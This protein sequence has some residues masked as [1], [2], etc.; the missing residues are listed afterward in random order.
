LIRQLLTESMVLGVVGG[1]LGLLLAPVA[2]SLLSRFLATAIS[3]IALPFAVDARILVFTSAASL[4]VVLLFGLAPAF[5]ATRL[6][7]CPLFKGGPSAGAPRRVAPGKLLLLTE[8]AISCVLLAGAI[9]FAR[10][11][12]KLT[13]V[14]VG[15]DA[16]NIALM[17]FSA[18]EPAP[19]G[20]ERAELFHRI[21]DRLAGIPG[22]VAAGLSSEKLFS[23][24]TWTES[25]Y[26]PG[27]VPSAAGDRESVML[28]IS[29]G[30]FRTMNTRILRGRDFEARDNVTGP[31][32]AIVNEAMAKHYLGRTD[33]LGKTFRINHPAFSQ[34]LTVI[35]VV[36]DT[37]YRNYR[38]SSPR[39]VYL[40]YL[41]NP[42]LLDE[43]NL[44]VRTKGDPEK[45]I[46]TFW[47]AARNESSQLR[48]AN[49]T[50]QS[51]VVDATIAQD[52]M[53]AELSGFFGF[54]AALLVSIGLY[55]LT[56]Y[57]VSRR[58]AEIGVRM[59]LGARRWQVIRMVLASSMTLVG[60]GVGLGLA[61][62]L[63][64]GRLVEGL[65][66]DVTGSDAVT[67]LLTVVTLMTVGVVAAYRPALRASRLDPLISLKHE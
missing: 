62:A 37:K 5:A 7:L 50:T 47:Q 25:V 2:A 13:S 43:P 41:Q 30:F 27:F 63:M 48:L 9:L 38:E 31:P 23:G 53:L 65:L 14:D 67:L 17:Q 55:G 44:S 24:N 15:F 26:A 11:L 51:R 36:Q 42:D 40:P 61:V 28:V 4:G 3:G 56:S 54:V 45:M 33:V 60:L 16:E 1:A 20:R 58:T 10:S 12:Q 18:T 66:F 29:P 46:D 6:D 57:E 49:A 19:K 22:V 34:P 35:G 21:L 32:V 59:A 52:R 8:V 64:V 39:M